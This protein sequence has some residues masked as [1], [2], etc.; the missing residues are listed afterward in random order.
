MMIGD[1]EEDEDENAAKTK[2]GQ[3]N[4]AGRLHG[5]YKS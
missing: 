4:L 2:G 3:R 1:R 5:S